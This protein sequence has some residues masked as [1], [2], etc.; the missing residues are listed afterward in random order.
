MREGVLFQ[1]KEEEELK[2]LRNIVHFSNNLE[3]SNFT[4][5]YS[6]NEKFILNVPFNV[7]FFCYFADLQNMKKEVE[8]LLNFLNGKKVQERYWGFTYVYMID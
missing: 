7:V 5:P 6:L 8:M 1:K 3:C 2:R 4:A